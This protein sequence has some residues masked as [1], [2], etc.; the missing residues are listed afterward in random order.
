MSEITETLP[1]Q[2]AAPRPPAAPP[3]APASQYLSILDSRR[4]S[5]SLACFLSIMPG[6]GLMQR[7]LENLLRNALKFTP[8]GG[9]VTLRL[10][11]GPGAVSVAVTDTGCGQARW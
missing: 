2:A 7:V 4:K 8:P 11:T 5:P 1:P 9:E 10:Q 6:L 3:A